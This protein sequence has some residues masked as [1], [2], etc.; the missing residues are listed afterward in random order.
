MRTPLPFLYFFLF[1]ASFS[2]HA[3]WTQA[4]SGTSAVLYTVEVINAD[5]AYAGG[6]GVF[7]RSVNG[8]QNWTSIP[9]I[10]TSNQPI[11]GLT[12][13]DLHFFNSQT[14]VAVG[15]RTNTVHT[16]LRTTDGG[17]HWSVLLTQNDPQNWD[18][19]IRKVDFIN[20]GQGWCVGSSGK[21]RRTLDGGATWTDLPDVPEPN[22]S[23]LKTVDFVNA[24]IG[25]LSLDYSW[26]GGLMM[27]TTNGGQ[28]WTGLVGGN[29]SEIHFTN[30]DTGYYA[31]QFYGFRTL[32]GG[33]D[34]AFLPIPDEAPARRFAFQNGTTGF[35]LAD[36]GVRQTKNGGQFWVES[37]FPGNNPMQM[38]DFDWAPGFQTGIAVGSN[39]RIY[40]T[41]NGGGTAVPMAYFQTDPQLVTFCKDQVIQLIN[42]APAGE[43]SSVWTVDGAVYSTDNDVSV[44]F[45]D[46]GGSH[47]VQLLISNGIV[48]DTFQRTIQI[49][50]SLDFNFGDVV[51]LPGTQVC[52]GGNAFVQIHHP[53]VN[54]TYIFSVNDQVIAQQLA[55]DTSV[56]EFQTLFLN[57]SAVLKVFSS[58]NTFCGSSYHEEKQLIEV[59]PFPSANL[60]WSITEHVCVNGQAAVTVQNS[61][62][63]MRYW[64]VENG[65]YT[66]SDTLDGTGGTL[67]FF[68]YPLTQP[69]N[70]QVRASNSIGC[71]NWIGS[72]LNVLIDFFYLNVDTTHLY[73]VA[74]QPLTIQNP[75]EGLGGSDWTFGGPAQPATSQDPI[76]TV[77]YPTAG[78]FPFTYGYRS[79]SACQGFLEGNIEVFDAAED[80][81]GT[82]CWSQR[83][84]NAVYVE[85]NIM[86]VKVDP[87]GNY[88]VTGAGFQPVGFW[89]TMNL[90]LNK[91]DP[92]G[93]LLWSKKVNAEDPANSFD[94]RTTYG[95]SIAFDA[96]GNAYLSGSYS[97][98]NARVFGVDFTRST[99]FFASASQGFL[100]KL[101]PEGNVIW[102]SNFQS[103]L[104]YEPS[105]PTS[106]VVLND[107]VHL[108]LRAKS[109]LMFQPDGNL[110][111][112]GG[113]N[114]VAWYI[115]LDENGGFV[116]DLPL[117]ESLPNALL[118]VT[119]PEPTSISSELLTFKS[120]R[121]LASP[122]GNLLMNGAFL[123][124]SELQFGNVPIVPLDATFS[125]KNHFIAVID[126][127][128]G[129][130]DNAFCAV[131][132]QTPQN[133]FPAWETDAAGD[134]YLGFG[135]DGST[136]S[137]T[138]S[139]RIGANFSATTPNRSYI[140]KF[141]ENGDLLWQEK[142][143]DQLFAGFVKASDN[144]IWALIR[145]NRVA[146]FQNPDGTT[147]GTGSNGGYDLLLSRIGA[148]GALLGLQH[149][150][151]TE[152]E[153]PVALAAAGPTTLGIVSA[154]DL[155]TFLNNPA[156]AYTLRVW[157]ENEADCPTLSMAHVEAVSNWQISP[158]PF[159][160]AFTCTFHFPEPQNNIACTLRSIDGSVVR[161]RTFG[162]IPAGEFP[163]Q[164]ETQQIPAGM[165]L[166]ELATERGVSVR[167]V[168]RWK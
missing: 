155:N 150:G 167:K 36:N 66:V 144:S 16:I 127:A 146:G 39:G 97:A 17:A 119:F 61:E 6:A 12:I 92:S 56:I 74:G 134:I 140:A 75:T 58:I 99:A 25:Y 10:N 76:P 128:I 131:S 145:Y 124:Y 65:L 81:S 73:G 31:D 163:V 29:F 86:D 50:P 59:V 120:P 123:G 1:F 46:Y 7:L 114:A 38:H 125:G 20:N 42:P 72:P 153:Q 141:S 64:L 95:L 162:R 132:L 108:M 112:N 47:T 142:H 100:F 37:R 35:M 57:E 53:T 49:E 34:G 87:D 33:S 3:Q 121:L 60:N 88:W 138:P 48:S 151:G 161:T 67:T 157:S 18:G 158:N 4:N 77:T 85:Q 129:A 133:N 54:M 159:G 62:P 71:M 43:W 24:Q 8:G 102:H 15:V 70:Y 115:V 90:F 110:A 44:S 165:Y 104:D 101:D 152:N 126:P 41:S 28:T 19:G 148:D 113:P 23:Y 107:Q 149:F 79:Q 45:P 118:G 9:I 2:L 137:Y 78:I 135:L 84:L 26:G 63:G 27:K 122:T 117:T 116:R 106:V 22:L 5:T 143:A 30:P 147:S 139:V 111:T 98:D 103:T 166:F 96:A 160:D 21:V 168:V 130:C 55:Y 164:F 156:N 51:W 94:Y 14:G 32:A 13:N 11:N 69:V 52:Q 93:V 154:D 68:S 136:P 80:L 40:R 109:W 83:L 89:Y 82:A 105:V 91:Y